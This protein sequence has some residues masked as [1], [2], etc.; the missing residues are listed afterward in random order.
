MKIGAVTIEGARFMI[1]GPGFLNLTL[2]NEAIGSLIA[3]MAGDERLGIAPDAVVETVV[4]DYSSV[5]VAKEM[6]IGHIRTTV[7][8]FYNQYEGFQAILGRPLNPRLTTELNIPG[9]TKIYGGEAEADFNFGDLS[10]SLGVNLLHSEIGRFFA[11]DPR[12]LPPAIPP[13]PLCDPA[14]G[15]A[16]A[17]CKDLTGQ[18]QTYAP[19]V[20]FNA[21]AEY[22][23][24]LGESDTLTPRA[25]F[26][27]VGGQ[28][29]TLF[30]DETRGDKL[31]DRNIL[32][33]QLAFNHGSWTVTAYATNLTNQH[34][35]GALNSGLDFAGPPRQYG[36]RL[37]KVF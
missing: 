16:T 4:V 3:E 20:T 21:S 26:G 31:E 10:L 23:F 14:T 5:N 12:N 17:Y 19:N 13:P 33:A 25:S 15:P 11:V 36:V 29:A 32:N 35:V 9:T 34:Y 1:A 7:D 6:H 27:H 30:E 2:R 8:G 22:V 37:H 18:R 24:H 28:W